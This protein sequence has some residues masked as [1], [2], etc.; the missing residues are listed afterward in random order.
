MTSI[1]IVYYSMYGH[2]HDLA[3]TLAE[4]VE[5]AGGEAQLRLVPEL[6]PEEVQRSEGVRQAKER[7]ADVAEAQVDELGDFDGILFGSPTRYG[8]ATGQLQNFL[9]QTGPLWQQGTLLGKAAG[10][11][12]GAATLHGG[13]ESTI[14]GMST[15]AY[16]HGMV[17]VPM[18]Y[19]VSEAVGGT[20][21]GGGPYGPSHWSPMGD[22][23]QGL[24]DDE[25]EIALQYG[26]H[27]T[28]VAERLAA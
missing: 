7:T 20:S 22:D 6:L 3:T 9:D 26:Q 10:F 25:I 12:T 8:S 17:I 28:G 19:A 4:G 16:H 23:K 18:G 13:H 5:K 2:T 15:F 11:F 27:F 14:L 21:T 24:S 1:G